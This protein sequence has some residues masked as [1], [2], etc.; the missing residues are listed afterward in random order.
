[1]AGFK[2][3]EIE[4][5]FGVSE[6]GCLLNPRGQFPSPILIKRKMGRSGLVYQRYVKPHQL[7]SSTETTMI[8]KVGLRYLYR[9]IEAGK[10]KSKR[11]GDRLFFISRDV[12]KLARARGVHPIPPNPE[13]ERKIREARRA[14][15]LVVEDEKG[16]L[17]LNG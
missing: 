9:M 5:E 4:I 14:G 7:L 8:L 12:Q 3:P 10:I 6:S 1:M 11:V 2:P 16:V 15:S 13:L 17:W